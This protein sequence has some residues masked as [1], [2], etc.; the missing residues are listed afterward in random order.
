MDKVIVVVGPTGVGKT[1]M[2]VALAKYFN[3]EVISGDSMQIYKTMDIG[4]AKVTKQEMDG[5]VHHLIDIKNPDESYSVKDFQDEVRKKIKEITMRNKLPIIVGGT[6]L[7]IKAALYDYQFSDSQIEHQEY[8][9]KYQEYTN[10]QLYQYLLEIDEL[11]A[12]ELHPNN[13]QRVFW[14]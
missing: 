14:S 7:Y 9:K 4:T 10:E 11:S 3:G 2:G 5:V 6:G 1:K 8:V 13:R 12:K